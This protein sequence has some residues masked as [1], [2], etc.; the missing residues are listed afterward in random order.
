MELNSL[1]NFERVLCQKQAHQVL[2]NLDMWFRSHFN[3]KVY[4]H[5]GIGIAHHEQCV[6]SELIHV[7]IQPKLF[8]FQMSDQ[9]KASQLSREVAQLLESRETK[10]LALFRCF[11]LI[12]L[13]QVQ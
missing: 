13:Q 3:E 8:Q 5:R 10:Y 6:L 12:Q 7:D 2:S 4:G 9:F 11:N 1:N